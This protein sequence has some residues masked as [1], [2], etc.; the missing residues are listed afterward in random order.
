MRFAAA[1]LLATSAISLSGCSAFRIRADLDCAWAKPIRF[2]DETKSWLD[3]LLWPEAAYPDF[4]QIADHNEL[5]ERF[6]G[7][8]REDDPR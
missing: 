5:F 2:S 8:P 3:G 1:L 4:R 7:A 6:C